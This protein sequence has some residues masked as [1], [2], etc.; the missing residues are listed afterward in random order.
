MKTNSIGN[1]TVFLSFILTTILLSA[2]VTLPGPE[3][4]VCIPEKSAKEA[5]GT[6]ESKSDLT[7]VP[8]EDIVSGQTGSA[9]DE[10]PTLIIKD[11]KLEEQAS[12]IVIGNDGVP[13]K[14]VTEGQLVEFS[15]KAVDPDGDQLTYK[16]TSPL[17]AKGKWQTKIGDAGT[18]FSTITA[19]DG[20]SETFQRVRIIINAA[21]KAPLLEAFTFVSAKEGDIIKIEP[22]ATDPEN[23]KITFTYSGWMTSNTYETT[24]SDAGEHTVTVTA[25][26]GK[27]E[28][29]KELRLMISNVN[30]APVVGELPDL[31]IRENDFAR[32]NYVAADLDKDALEAMYSQPFDASGEWQTNYEDA[33]EYPITVT[34]SDGE[35][36][37]TKTFKL[38]VQNVNRKPAITGI[39]DV[40]VKEGETITFSP[41]ASDPDGDELTVSYSGWMTDSSYTTGYNDQGSH[42]VYITVSDGAEKT[43]MLSIVHVEN[44]NRP[45]VFQLG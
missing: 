28:V 22:I 26:D 40:S 23:D 17:D 13:T 44:V 41:V 1:L 30:R 4:K 20:K 3:S 39:K 14:I 35:L 37:D 34:V 15:L 10:K 31:T 42:D 7:L 29:S 21:N 38:T 32:I 24:F 25:S 45:P 16:F 2:C 9:E 5:A 8:V 6:T 33:G 19:S 18:Y 36:S 27:N 12:G 11:E 43:T